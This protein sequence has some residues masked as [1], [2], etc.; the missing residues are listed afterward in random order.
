M[1]KINV[2][3]IAKLA[4]ISLT[5]VEKKK[6]EPQ[7]EAVLDYIEKL[8]SADTKNTKETNQVTGLQ[9]IEREDVSEGSLS[10]EEAI[11]QA[12][13]THNGLFEVPVIIEEAVEL[14]FLL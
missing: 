14:W 9:N 8:S 5:N 10:Q 4:N 1:P 11:S 6:F 13:S 12:K 3:H 7:L 2:D